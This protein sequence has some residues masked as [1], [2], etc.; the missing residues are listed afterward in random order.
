MT[1]PNDFV[2]LHVH[3]NYSILDAIS[4]IDALVSEA[5]RCKYHAMA[6]TDHGNMH[7][8]F[9]FY[10]VCKENDIKPIVGVEF[11]CARRT[12]HEPKNK[13][14]PT[15]HLVILARNETGYKNMLK[16]ATKASLEGFS[17]VPRIDCAMISI[18]YLTR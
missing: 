12:I 17:Y 4:S 10:K 5:G 11:Y 8:S 9:E 16:L 13:T 2:H 6:L 14:N 7:G 3:S 18:S 1:S 15:D